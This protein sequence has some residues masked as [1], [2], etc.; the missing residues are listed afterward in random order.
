MLQLIDANNE[1]RRR[2]EVDA[3][4]LTIRNLLDEVDLMT[5]SKDVVVLV[6]DGF[7]C[8]KRRR[9]IYPAY[10]SKRKAGLNA[11]NIFASIKF[12]KELLKYT[13]AIQ[14]EVPGYEADDVIA[15]LT[16]QYMGHMPIRIVSNDGDYL[17]LGVPTTRE[18]DYG[19]PANLIRLYK[20]C[21]GDPSDNIPGIRGFGAKTW[22]TVDKAL[23]E[24]AVLGAIYSRPNAPTL[25][26]VPNVPK[27]SANWFHNNVD[28]MIQMWTI[29]GFIP[30][31]KVDIEI[32]STVGKPHRPAIE[33]ALREFML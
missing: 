14:V 27:T 21:V 28:E 16:E 23:L 25:Y 30:V 13:A 18:T 19:V 22:E 29:V 3:S 31:P 4:G 20:T 6:W 11:E 2:L 9:D 24:D 32:N 5:R 8:N 33:A 26:D 1:Y 17:Q 12:C 10:K 15:T 7:D